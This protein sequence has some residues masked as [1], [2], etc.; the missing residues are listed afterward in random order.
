MVHPSARFIAC[1]S[2]VGTGCLIFCKTY[3]DTVFDFAV[4]LVMPVVADG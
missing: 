3:Y 2:G 1:S 4:A